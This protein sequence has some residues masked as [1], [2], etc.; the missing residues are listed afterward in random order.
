MT[1]SKELERI[2]KGNTEKTSQADRLV[3]LCISR[4]PVFFHDQ[5]RTPFV[6]VK[7]ADANV[8]MPIR[9][10]QFKTW[11]ANLMWQAEQKAPGTEGVNSAINVLQGKALMEGEQYTLYNRVAPAEDG[12]WIDMCDAK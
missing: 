1:L 10:R 12:V 5:H 4:Q 2:E 9:S 8:I 11:L 7:Q 3:T 6:R